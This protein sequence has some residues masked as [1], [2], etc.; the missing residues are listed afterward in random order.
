MTDNPRIVRASAS[1][2]SKASARATATLIA[3]MPKDHP[4]LPV[5]GRA[6]AEWGQFEHALNRTIWALA[7]TDER[8]TA[9]IT[10]Q[11]M[12][13]PNRCRAIVL[14][15]KVLGITP[16]TIKPYNKLRSEAQDIGDERARLVHDSWYDE[17]TT[18][19]PLQFRA[20]AFADQRFG[21]VPVTQNDV[22]STIEKIIDLTKQALA[23]HN[24]VLAELKS[25][26]GTP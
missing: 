26:R 20:M 8:V 17:P 22:E 23:L 24:A 10:S 2:I 9:C 15:G 11:L 16:K 1:S 25:L 12:G 3:P 14:I 6:A 5:I 19:G 18:M 7:G 21:F 13:A 4:L